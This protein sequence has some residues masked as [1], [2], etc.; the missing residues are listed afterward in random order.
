MSKSTKILIS[1]IACVLVV[2]IA[3]VGVYSAVGNRNKS[4]TS[5]NTLAPTQQNT[6]GS[7]EVTT[8]PAGA[9]SFDT[10]IPPASSLDAQIIGKWMDSANMSG[11][12]FKPGGAASVTY[13]NLDVP[14][15]NLPING[16]VNGSYVLTGS[17]LSVSFSIYTKTITNVYTASVEN[18]TLT[19][20]SQDDGEVSTYRRQ[21]VEQTTT[22]S[23]NVTAQPAT[24]VVQDGIYGSW[25]SAD[26]SLKYTFN[27]T[28]IVNISFTN[29][30]IDG[31]KYTDECDGV[32]II[33]DDEIT[34]Q[35]TALSKQFVDEYD[36]I[37][38]G[39]SLELKKSRKEKIL[40]SRCAQT[41]SPESSLIGNWHDGS[42]MSGFNFKESGIVEV[43][44]VNFTV[45]VIN[46]PITGSYTGGYSVNGDKLTI[47]FS[48]YKKQIELN[49][50]YK[51]DGNTLIL[52]DTEDGKVTSYTK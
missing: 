33:D 29:A 17:T 43:T 51:I 41:A 11:F 4:D 28:G 18:D 48:I 45:P 52:T 14:F 32:F 40:F 42:N 31:R 27:K 46:M 10:T 30:D 21:T 5:G 8:D 50:T 39:N 20:V 7:G 23:Q 22:A 25:Q 44:Y 36:F 49:Y 6:M 12:E 9:S 19:L 38:S 3:I 26:G 47:N 24:E 34:I 2:C 37:V 1:V 15:L 35:Y 13:V 16:T